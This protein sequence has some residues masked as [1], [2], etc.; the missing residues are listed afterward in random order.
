[1]SKYFGPYKVL[2]KIGSVAYKLELP[3]G[4]LIH[5]VFHISQ[6]KPFIA[7]YTPVYDE[8]PVITDL[9]AAA[10]TPEAILDRCLVKKGNTTIPQ[11]KVT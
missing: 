9:I 1:V 7:D 8:L 4:S 11:V 2:E 10:T 3:Q 6:L 5:S